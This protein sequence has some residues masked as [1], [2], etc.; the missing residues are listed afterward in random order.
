MSCP[1]PLLGA[2]AVLPGLACAQHTAD[3]GGE[4]SEEQ[5]L[6]EP[7]SFSNR[8]RHRAGAVMNAWCVSETVS[9]LST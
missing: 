5:L 2:G 3:D 8:G 9:L 7:W 6:H 1:H 4:E